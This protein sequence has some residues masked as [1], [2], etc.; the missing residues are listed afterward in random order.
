MIFV[1]LHIIVTKPYDFEGDVVTD[2]EVT[3][4]KFFKI[5]E[6]LKNKVL[7]SPLFLISG[8]ALLCLKIP[9]LHLLVLL[10]GEDDYGAL[11]E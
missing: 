6:V 10:T 4:S 7:L 3:H 9:I 5:S 2:D 11:V 1:T 8:R